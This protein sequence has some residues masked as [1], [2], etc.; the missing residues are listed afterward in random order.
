M[1]GLIP[2]GFQHVGECA[3]HINK[4]VVIR[5]FCLRQQHCTDWTLPALF[6]GRYLESLDSSYE[7]EIMFLS[8][9]DPEKPWGYFTPQLQHRY[10][11]IE[12][13]YEEIYA[14]EA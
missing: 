5:R 12:L 9:I 1:D 2:Y 13:P 8:V 4:V 3:L 11:K 10:V 14:F 7:I 6:A